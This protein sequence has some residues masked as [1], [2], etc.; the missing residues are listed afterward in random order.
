V[1]GA[2]EPGRRVLDAYLV[3]F[4]AYMLAPL[5]VMAA[6]AFNAYPQPSVTR[7]DGLTLAWFARLAADERLVRGLLNSLLVGAGVVAASLALGLAGA[8]VLAR[9][10]GRAAGGLLYTAMVS[11]ILTPGVILGVSTL[12]LWRRAGVGGGLFLAGV[13]QTTFVASY[14]MLLFAARLQRLD[15]G[16]EEAARDLGAGP[17]LVFRRITLPFLAPT[18]AAAAGVAFLQ[19]FENYNTTVFAIGGEWTLVT[20]VGSRFRFGLS[21]AL[22]AL[23][24]LFVLATVAAALAYAGLRERAR[25]R[26]RRRG[27]AA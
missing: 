13:A 21:P 23:G 10:E 5:L 17:L 1:G 22:N 25:R 7:W 15:R 9:L 12:V 11:P 19:S 3:L 24:V 27:R 4:L 16:L 26:G 14:C 6:A 2:A 8:L 18:A 20:E